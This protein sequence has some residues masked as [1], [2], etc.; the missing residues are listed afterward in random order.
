M[1]ISLHILV[2]KYC[3]IHKD[4]IRKFVIHNVV[5]LLWINC[6][7]IRDLSTG[8]ST[9]NWLLILFFLVNSKWVRA[10]FLS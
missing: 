7:F 1:W 10:S 2:D 8:L 6:G 4:Y 3:V 5:V 9:E